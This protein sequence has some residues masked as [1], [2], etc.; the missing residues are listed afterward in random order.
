MYV[1]TA[2]R[3]GK[4]FQQPDRPTASA[5]NDDDVDEGRSSCKRERPACP[6]NS[7]QEHTKLIKQLTATWACIPGVRF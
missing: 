5:S 6:T 7:H 3:L 4:T 1:C 2:L